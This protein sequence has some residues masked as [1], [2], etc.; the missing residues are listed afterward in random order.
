MALSDLK[1]SREGP[2]VRG[3][4]Q[5][6]ITGTNLNAGSNVVVMLASSPTS[7]TGNT[8]QGQ[9]QDPGA[10]VAGLTQ[11][12]FGGGALTSFLRK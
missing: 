12:A 1:P 10:E 8:P 11:L 3:G 9:L 5:V 6:T 2:R 4:T 7:S